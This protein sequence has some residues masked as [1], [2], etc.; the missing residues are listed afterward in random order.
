MATISQ[1]K[2][3]QALDAWAE[4][5]LKGKTCSKSS[6]APL[7]L[8]GLIS[9]GDI[10]AQRLVARLKKAGCDAHYGAIDISLYRD[11]FEQKREKL[12]LRTSYLPFSTD[13]MQLI[14]IDDVVYTGRTI[15]AALNAI[16]DYGR[17]AKV[18]LHCLVQR[19]GRE[20]P[21]QPDYCAFDIQEEGAQGVKLQLQELDGQDLLTY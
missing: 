19:P 9:R 14:L 10:L 11:D 21:I 8:V 1:E 6:Q 13:G 3:D 12:A 20:L 5:I 4:H 7:A 15:R 2:I 18:E 16:F 17:P